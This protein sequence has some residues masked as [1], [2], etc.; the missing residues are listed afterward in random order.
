M[1]DND[2]RFMRRGKHLS[3]LNQEELNL[4][5]PINQRGSGKERALLVLHGF[6]SSPAV[7]RFIIPKLNNYDAIIC[8]VLPGH[9][10][11][12]EAFSQ[13]KSAEWLKTANDVCEGL[14]KEYKK[15]DVLGLSLGGLLACHLSQRFSLNHLF[16]LAPALKLHMNIDAMLKLAKILQFLG[17]RYM[18]NAAGNLKTNTNAEIAYKKLPVATIIEMLML[19]KQY[20]WVAPT[21]PTD[22]FLG[23]Y[24][25]VVS[26]AE[27]GQLFA[28]LANVSIHWLE[29]SAHV[30]PLDN[31]LQEII[32][33]INNLK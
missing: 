26:S 18:R 30:L 15:V 25:A 12:I 33:C 28:P 16:L 29:N 23:T 8:P 10:Q 3:G 4:L 7:Y 32:D 27:V 14:V 2:F 13:C 11:S 6:S 24:D 1:N 31:D 20:Q 17:F 9:A 21:C 5:Q 19:A 22:L